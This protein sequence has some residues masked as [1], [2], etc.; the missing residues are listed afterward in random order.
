MLPR[1]R[2]KTLAH[3]VEL[4]N[5]AQNRNRRHGQPAFLRTKKGKLEVG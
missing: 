1:E 4:P 2:V 5:F 3:A